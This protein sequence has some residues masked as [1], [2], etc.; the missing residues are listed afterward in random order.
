LTVLT[1]YCKSKMFLG[2]ANKNETAT[3]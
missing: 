1:L 3:M 2:I